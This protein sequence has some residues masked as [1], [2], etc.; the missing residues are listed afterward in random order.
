MVGGAVEVFEGF[1]VRLLCAGNARHGQEDVGV[2]G[3]EFEGILGVEPGGGGG[4]A[5]EV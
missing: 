1:V 5:R 2:V 3:G 4:M